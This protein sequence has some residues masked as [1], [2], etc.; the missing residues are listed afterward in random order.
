MFAYAVASVLPMSLVSRGEREGEKKSDGTEETS[1][2]DANS[3]EGMANE[4]S[5]IMN[6]LMDGVI[7]SKDVPSAKALGEKAEGYIGS[8]G[9]AG[10][11]KGTA[12][13]Y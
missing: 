9:S 2:S 5:I 11:G 1:G 6:D 7:G 3:H 10:C 8:Q 12:R 4:I 13:P